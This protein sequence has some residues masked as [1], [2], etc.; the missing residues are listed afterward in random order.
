MVCDGAVEDYEDAQFNYDE[1]D[2]SEV[3]KLAYGSDSI[4]VHFNFFTINLMCVAPQ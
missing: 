3:C 2:Q 4:A 1:F